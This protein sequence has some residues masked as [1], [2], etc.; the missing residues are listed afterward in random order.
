M[1]I[2][3]KTVK[4]HT[5]TLSDDELYLLHDALDR[6]HPHDMTC[7]IERVHS[8]D[9]VLEFLESMCSTIEATLEPIVTERE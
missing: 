6:V 7:I 9:C 8:I 5:L 2:K 3:T 4:S 1:D